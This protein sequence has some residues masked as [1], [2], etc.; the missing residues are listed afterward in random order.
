MNV[1]SDRAPSSDNRATTRF[2]TTASTRD[3]PESEE[4]AML[5]QR[6]NDP[7]SRRTVTTRVPARRPKTVPLLAGQIGVRESYCNDLTVLGAHNLVMSTLNPMAGDAITADPHLSPLALHGGTL[8]VHAL[9]SGSSAVDHGENPLRLSADE[10]GA[11]RAV[12]ATDVGAYE[13]QVGDDELFYD[14]FEVASPP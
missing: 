3:D 14:G 1:I 5:S 2:A 4:A 9:A 6:S 10:R 8:P 13:R 11:T 7:R 12:G